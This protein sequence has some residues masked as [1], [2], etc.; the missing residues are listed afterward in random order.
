M[1]YDVE[2]VGKM[3]MKDEYVLEGKSRRLISD[4]GIHLE[5]LR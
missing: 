2:L 5:G 3:T 4:P 1:F